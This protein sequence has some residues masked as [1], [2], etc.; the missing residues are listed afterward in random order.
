MSENFRKSNRISSADEIRIIQKKGVSFNFF[1][2]RA[3]RL[4][5][6]LKHPRMAVAITKKAGNAVVR[7]RARRHI[8]EFFRKNKDLLGFFDYYFFS[9]LPLASYKKSDWKKF[10]V[11][12]MGVATRSA[13]V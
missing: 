1:P 7:V 3:Y 11:Q 5:N 12:W 8:R 13:G 10:G 9:S 6:N 2:F 4:K